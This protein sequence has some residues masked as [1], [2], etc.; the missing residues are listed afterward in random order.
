VRLSIPD[1]SIARVLIVG[2]VMLDRYWYGAAARISPEAPVPVV[3]VGEIEERAGG[4]GNVALNIASLGATATVLGYTGDDEAAVLLHTLLTRRGVDCR[5]TRV[6][7][8]ATITKLR[9]VSRHQQLIRLDFENG[10]AYENPEPL[11]AEY[12]RALPAADVVILSDYGKGTLSSTG[13]LIQHARAACKP[14]M[15]D[16]K[17]TDFDRYRGATAITP[18]QAEFEAVVGSCAGEDDLIDKGHEL[19]KELSLEALLITRSEKGVLLLR[20]GCKP[21]NFPTRARDV[22]DV[23]GAGDTVIGVLG[24][25]LAAGLQCADATGIAN[26]AAG[27]VVSKLGTATVTVRE[28]HAA[29]HE[30]EPLPRGIVS[31]QELIPLLERA[32]ATGE[33]LVMT[34]G[35][36]DILHAGHV[37]YLSKAAQLGDRLLVAVNDDDSVRRLK[38]SNRP[39][40]SVMQ[41]MAVLAGLESV[42]WVVSFS[43]DTPQR[44]IE[45]LRP[46]VLVKGGDYRLEEI[47]GA[48]TVRVC[49]GEVVTL[50]YIDGY[51]TSAIIDAIRKHP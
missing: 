10:F 9:V 26:L 2:D 49:G 42:D 41:R 51:S 8:K 34:N 31:E 7:N 1:F 48:D 45:S 33:R 30:H 28:L 37:A 15:I 44:I 19:L 5:F 23:T 40:N 32:R 38:G 12:L 35:C 24:A 25:G 4:A 18:N 39:V 14:V 3:R 16:P 27:V 43:E 29:M 50:P 6:S 36:F 22:F 13:T 11:V 47:V 20:A 46:N 17:G 21:L